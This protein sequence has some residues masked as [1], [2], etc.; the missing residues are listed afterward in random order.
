MKS[1]VAYRFI[2]K[3]IRHGYINEAQQ[4]IFRWKN[5]LNTFLSSGRWNDRI[6]CYI[7]IKFCKSKKILQLL[8]KI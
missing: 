6:K 4:Y 2:L 5:E 8:Q 7:M 3:T 1:Y